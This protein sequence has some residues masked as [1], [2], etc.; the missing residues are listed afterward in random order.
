MI[1][2]WLVYLSNHCV[3]VTK[4]VNTSLVLS[5]ESKRDALNYL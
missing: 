3:S 2:G 4:S 5:L 1:P